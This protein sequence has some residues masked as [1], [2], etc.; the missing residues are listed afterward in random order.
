MKEKFGVVAIISLFLI[1]IAFAAG[2]GD[3]Q[4]GVHEPGTGIENP[5]IKETGQGTG[6]D[7]ENGTDTTTQNKGND[8]QIKTEQ[9]T[10]TNNPET[11]EQIRTQEQTQTQTKAQS[12]SYT[13]EGGKQLQ[14]QEQSGDMLQLKTGTA[15]AQTKM[16]MTQEQ[17]QTGTKLQVKLSN[18]Q[19]SEVKIMP[20]AASVKAIE[21]LQLKNCV[22]EEGCS[23][24][25]KE[26][27]QGEQIRAAYEIKTQKETKVFGLFKAKMQVQAQIDAENGEV[28]KA[29]KPWWSFLA[30]A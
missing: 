20:D 7:L 16:Q 3:S 14:I 5:E 15:S 19:S 10:Q 25:L 29:S 24:E 23:I 1:G 4:Q 12:G 18:G 26:V 11:G 28:I 22:S 9:Q 13:T 30:T 8:S 17:T 6:Q 21:R 27:G 2:T